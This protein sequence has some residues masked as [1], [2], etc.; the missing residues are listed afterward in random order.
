[1]MKLV[2]EDVL[3]LCDSLEQEIRE[4]ETKFDAIYG[5]PRG[6]LIPA[7]IL[8]H[9]LELPLLMG[10]PMIICKDKTVLVVDDIND[11][12]TTL[13]PYCGCENLQSVVLYERAESDVRSDFVG[14]TVHHNGWIVFPWEPVEKAT[15]DMA[16]Y[17]GRRHL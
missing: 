15:V 3:S 7:T 16:D 8:S 5:I 13:I 10:D 1:M 14:E 12:G 17:L 4:C 2:F 9:R 11:T 6:G